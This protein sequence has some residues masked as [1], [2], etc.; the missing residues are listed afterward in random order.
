M[1][2]KLSNLSRN[3]KKKIPKYVNPPSGPYKKKVKILS[4]FYDF[5]YPSISDAWGEKENTQKKQT[6]AG[7]CL[8]FFFYCEYFPKLSEILNSW[9]HFW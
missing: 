7:N 1:C 2:V 8:H 9:K 6:L 5:Q 4:F 3:V